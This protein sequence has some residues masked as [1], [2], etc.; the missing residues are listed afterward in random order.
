MALNPITP[1]QSYA[2]AN[3]IV[4]VIENRNFDLLSN[5][6]LDFISKCFGICDF[7]KLLEERKRP[8]LKDTFEFY[9][10][11]KNFNSIQV[12]KQ[13]YYNNFTQ[14]LHDIF[15]NKKIFD[16]IPYAHFYN[17][18]YYSSIYCTYILIYKEIIKKLNKK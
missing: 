9:G 6:S 7:Y 18:K 11:F 2:F 1:T 3:N 15:E 4:K 16:K 13:K 10:K 5:D 12:I 17:K 14:F 8:Y